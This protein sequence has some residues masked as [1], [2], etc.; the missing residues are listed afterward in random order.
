MI[1]G[2][3]QHIRTLFEGDVAGNR[4]ETV[5]IVG[6]GLPTGTYTVRLVGESETASTRVVL[7]R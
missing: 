1:A 2:D 4:D 3:Q 5:R 7:V 6:L